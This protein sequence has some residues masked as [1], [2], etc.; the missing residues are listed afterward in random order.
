[1]LVLGVCGLIPKSVT[2]KPSRTLQPLLY[3]E[4]ISYPY[5]SLSL[6]KSHNA[7]HGCNM[8]TTEESLEDEEPM[9]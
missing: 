7:L 5:Y 2:V 6:E 8:N 4:H 3:V 9:C 1:M